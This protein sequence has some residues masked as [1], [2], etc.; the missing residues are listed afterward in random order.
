MWNGY[1]II[2]I[3]MNF[4]CVFVEFR[5][6]YGQTQY[7]ENHQ[8]PSTA[9]RR[10]ITCVMIQFRSDSADEEPRGLSQQ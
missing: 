4:R 7:P 5:Q 8:V 6:A 9:V 2:S 10:S 1:I 3:I